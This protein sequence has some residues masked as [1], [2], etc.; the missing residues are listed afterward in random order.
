MLGNLGRLG[1]LIARVQ[2]LHQL[3][4]QLDVDLLG[5]RRAG[6]QARDMV[7]ARLLGDL[8][9][10]GVLRGGARLALD[11]RLQ[12]FERGSHGGGAFL[13]HVEVAGRGRVGHG[14]RVEHVRSGAVGGSVGVRLRR[15]LLLLGRAS[16]HQAERADGC[17]PDSRVPHEA[18]PGDIGHGNPSCSSGGAFC[19]ARSA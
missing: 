3:V 9:P 15:G 8:R 4:L 14:L 1:L 6:E 19:T 7:V 10:R 17:G 5:V 12:V 16:G 2:L 18:S 11:G 13:N